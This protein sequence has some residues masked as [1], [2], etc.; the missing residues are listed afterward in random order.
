MP[1]R[2]TTR[3][4]RAGARRAAGREPDPYEE[5]EPGPQEDRALGDEEDYG[6]EDGAREDG[7]EG[8]DEGGDEE[9]AADA[10]A[11]VRGREAE[12][13]ARQRREAPGPMSVVAAARAAARS[14]VELTGKQP[15]SVT[16]VEPAENGWIVSV[17]VVE[18]RRVP[19]SADILALYEAELDMDGSLVAYRRTKRYSR[20]RSYGNGAR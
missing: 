18:D 13:S 5:E 19:S 3:D 7:D 20:S 16:A 14:V 2:R 1:V 15:E 9:D 4:E 10:D 6:D 8:G 11:A 12:P 17:E